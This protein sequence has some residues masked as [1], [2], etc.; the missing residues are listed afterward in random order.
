MFKLSPAKLA[1]TLSGLAV[2]LVAGAGLAS[3]SPDL[4]PA[5][6]STCSYPQLVSALNEQGPEAAAVFNQNPAL[7]LGLQQFVVSGP[8]ARR[9]M[10]QQLVS[11]PGIDPYLPSIEQAFVTCNQY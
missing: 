1:V 9:Q 4:G 3:A 2:S 11:T 8:A 7:Q 6:N 5:V 10:A